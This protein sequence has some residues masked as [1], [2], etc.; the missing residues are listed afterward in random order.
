MIKIIIFSDS[1]K[2]FEESIKEYEKRLWKEVEI[3]KLKPSKRKEEQEIISEETNILKEKLEKE[4]WYKILLYIEWKTFSTEDFYEFIESKKQ[5]YSDLI[6]II[7]WAY[8]VNLDKIDKLIDFKFSFSQ[9]TF[10]HSMA[11]LILLEQIYRVNMIKK[12]TG[13]HH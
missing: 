1:F 6:F 12:G 11:Y 2:H 10:P 9:M 8:W 5:N 3:I 7:W 4:K 13:Y